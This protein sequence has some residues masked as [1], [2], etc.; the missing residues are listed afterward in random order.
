MPGDAGFQTDV[1][2]AALALLDETEGPVLVDYPIEIEDQS[3]APLSCT[4][5]PA[6]VS[7]RHPAAAE[8]LGLRAAYD[9]TVAATGGRTSLGKAIS[10]DDVADALDKFVQIAD[11]TSW[12]EVGLPAPPPK[13]AIDIRSY[14]VEA[15]LSLVDHV[16]GARQAESWL[17]T[18]TE[19]G[20]VLHAAQAALKAADEKFFIWYYVTPMTQTR[21]G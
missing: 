13:V 4:I 3:D 6:D 14:Y 8:A 18:E 12:K 20:K 7:D 10:A 11:G 15:A 21:V 16:P 19:A 9:R 2:T 5:P 17:F 1:L